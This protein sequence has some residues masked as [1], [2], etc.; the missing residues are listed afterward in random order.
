MDSMNWLALI[1]TKTFWS[2]LAA[3]VVGVG[4]Y[5]TGQAPLMQALTPA[6]VGVLGI[7]LRDGMITHALGMPNDSV[8]AVTGTL[9]ASDP[10]SDVMSALTAT[11]AQA[12]QQA[13]SVAAKAISDGLK[14]MGVAQ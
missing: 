9:A 6:I 10:L 13:L 14:D 1:K 7:F 3:V 12:Q 5:A 2:S 11:V 4:S 8:P